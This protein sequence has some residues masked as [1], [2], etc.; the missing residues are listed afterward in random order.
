MG[1]TQN[2]GRGWV[3]AVE[4]KVSIIT[5]AKG[6]SQRRV[7]LAR[8]PFQAHMHHQAAVMRIL[9]RAINSR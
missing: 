3:A 6:K 8:R 5:T 7:Q 9:C 1:Y 2:T 4:L